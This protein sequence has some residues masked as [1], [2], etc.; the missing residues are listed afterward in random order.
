MADIS[1]MVKYFMKENAINIIL[2]S[3]LFSLLTIYLIVND[4]TFNGTPVLKRKFTISN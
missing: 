2:I 3:L 4:I 1:N